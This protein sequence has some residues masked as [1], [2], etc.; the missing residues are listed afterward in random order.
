MRCQLTQE[1][2]V[3]HELDDVAAITARSLSLRHN[4]KHRFK[5]PPQIWKFAVHRSLL[6]DRKF[7]RLRLF[8]SFQPQN[9]RNV[10]E[11]Q[12]GIWGNEGL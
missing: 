2:R 6:I 1:T 12:N 5:L 9:A 8:N 3:R 7:D 4:E 11:F 10:N